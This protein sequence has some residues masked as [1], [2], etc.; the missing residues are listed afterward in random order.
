MQELKNVGY[1]GALCIEIE[2]SDYED[3]LDDRKRALI[4]SGI[5]LRQY[6]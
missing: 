5:Y 4:E 2:D 6:L 3:S 1:N